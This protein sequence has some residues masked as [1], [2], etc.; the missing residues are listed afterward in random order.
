A[1]SN[2]LSSAVDIQLDGGAFEFIS[3]SGTVGTVTLGALSVTGGTAILRANPGNSGLGQASVILGGTFSRATASALTFVSGSGSVGANP[4]F[5]ASAASLTTNTNGIVGP[6][7]LTSTSDPLTGGANLGFAVYDPVVGMRP[8]SLPEI[9]ATLA[10]ATSTSNVRFSGTQSVL[11]GGQTVNTLTLNGAASTVNFAAGSDVLTL[12]AGGLLSGSDNAARTIGSAAVRGVISTS[13]PEFFIHN[14]ANTLTINSAIAG[15]TSPVFTSGGTVG[16]A[17]IRLTNANTYVGSAFSNGVIL[18]LDN[19]TG[20]GQSITGN[21]IM[22]GGNAGGGDTGTLANA[23]VR[24]LGNQQIADSAA[25]T[26]RGGSAWE[27]NGVSE[28]VSRVV[29]NSQGGITGGSAIT[30]GTGVLTLTDTANTISASSLD[31]VRVISHLAGRLSLPST[32]TVTVDQVAGGLTTVMGTAGQSNEQVGLAINA[33]ILAGGTINKEGPGVLQLGGFSSQSLTVNVNAGQLVIGPNTGGSASNYID[34]AVNL[35]SSGTL[36]DMRGN[37]NV[38]LGTISGVAGTIIKNFHPTAGSTLVTGNGVSGTFAGTFVSDFRYGDNS[39]FNVFKIGSGNWT[40]SGDSSTSLLGTFS[41]IGGTVTLNQATGKLGFFT[42][43]LSRG[44]V[45]TLN[46]ANALSDRL[47]GVRSIQGDRIFNNRGGVLNY[48]GSSAAAVVE[49]LGTAQNVA[50]QTVW[51]LTQNAGNQ[52]RINIVAFNAQTGTL[53]GA[54]T[55]NAG[56]TGTL[57][58]GAAG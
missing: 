37:S 19:Q 34:T 52:T 20:S 29:F 10:A 33:S 26:V 56:A 54:L 5:T 55:L 16:G 28:T 14:G 41:I 6:W 39:S 51:N 42:T 24:N 48:A 2:R 27:L 25:V 15:T 8:I 1:M 17:T 44:G 23:T 3:R 9:T 45:L 7:A 11:G 43:N 30:T 21:L 40:L 35:A 53:H 13:A 4:F 22:T 32:A 57:G 47:G 46:G 36:L 12:D 49:A 38:A 58:G 31:D 50:G 18:L